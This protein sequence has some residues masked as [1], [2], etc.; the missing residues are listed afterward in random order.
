MSN[1]T[2]VQRFTFFVAILSYLA[3]VACI[4]ILVFNNPGSDLNNPLSASLIA[5]VIFFI[6]VGIVLHVIGK[7]NLPNLKIDSDKRA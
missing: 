4:L 7:A 6:G 2:R 3:A 1:Q 5:S